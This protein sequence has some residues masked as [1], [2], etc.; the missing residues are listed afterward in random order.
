M[1]HSAAERVEAKT[2][3]RRKGMWRF[4]VGGIIS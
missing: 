3:M 4:I 1:V 2:A